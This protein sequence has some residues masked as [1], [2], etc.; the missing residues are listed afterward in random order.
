MNSFNLVDGIPAA[1]NRW[2][3]VDVLRDRWG[4]DGLLVTDYDVISE[5]SAHGY[6]PASRGLGEGS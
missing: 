4:F 1:A 2:L 3:M 5:M 6:A